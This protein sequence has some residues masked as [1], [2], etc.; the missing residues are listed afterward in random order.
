MNIEKLTSLADVIEKGYIVKED[1]LFAFTMS[2]VFHKFSSQALDYYGRKSV[3]SNRTDLPDNVKSEADYCGCLMGFTVLLWGDKAFLKSLEDVVVS[4]PAHGNLV[5]NIE[6]EASS[7]LGLEPIIAHEFFY[8]EISRYVS[9]PQAASVI[10]K[11]MAVGE[12]DWW[13]VQKEL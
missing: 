10:R 12:V 5:E 2:S 6:I 13:Q 7:I 1:K 11:L 8:G 4:Y 3:L 9:G